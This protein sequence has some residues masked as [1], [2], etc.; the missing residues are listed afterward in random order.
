[1]VAWIADE[2]ECIDWPTLHARVAQTKLNGQGDCIWPAHNRIADIV[3]LLAAIEQGY[4]AIPYNPRF[5]EQQLADLA[6]LNDF[7]AAMPEALAVAIF[8]SGSTGVAK[9]VGHRLASLQA[10]AERANQINPTA[11][12]DCWHMSLPLFHIGGL[13]VL[14]RAMQAGANL[15]LHG[16][17]ED[18]NHLRDWRITHAS[19]VATQL[20]RLVAQR[21][22]GL[23]LKTLLVGGGPVPALTTDLPMRYTYGMS[24]L[25][26]QACTQDRHGHMHWL[27][28]PSFD[29]QGQLHCHGDTL[30][31]GYVQGNQLWPPTLPFATGDIASYNQG[32][33]TVTGRIDNQ[34]IS[35]GEN[36]QPEYI[37]T[38]LSK[39]PDLS[40]VIV[41][42]VPDDEYGQRPF[43]FY[44][45]DGPWPQAWVQQQLASF[46]RPIGYAKMKINGLKP[47]RKALAKQAKAIVGQ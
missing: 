28:Q 42:P 30:F 23:A 26:S 31:A 6:Q 2:H 4:C 35:G 10:N 15:V 16:R 11:P 27:C 19:A 1:M 38:V 3:I 5:T 9:L 37:E 7:Q 21:P 17:V 43:A 33:L 14:F 34:F 45:G 41:V 36:I 47:N 25:G 32:R 12:G 18:V 40:H 13:A 44:Q 20:Q 39:H 46:M 22:T 24:E 8:T 29:D